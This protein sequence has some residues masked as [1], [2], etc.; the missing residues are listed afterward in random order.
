MNYAFRVLLAVYTVM[1]TQYLLAQSGPR[2]DVGTE[3]VTVTG[4]T[5]GGEVVFFARS[6]TYSGG[7][8]RLAK[9]AFVARDDDRDGTVTHVETV[10]ALSVWV[11]VDMES[12]AFAYGAPAGFEPRVILLPPETWKENDGAVNVSR[13]RAEFL[14]VRPRKGAW[15]LDAFQGSARD[16][17]G[18]NDANLRVNTSSMSPLTGKESPPP[19]PVK[20]DVLVVIDPRLLEVAVVAAQ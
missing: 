3:R 2:L 8:P 11:I 4:V 20:K 5:A 13:E 19:H 17:D 7:V 12:G 18:K 10:P 1:A 9:H 15:M 16:A 14:F 6:V